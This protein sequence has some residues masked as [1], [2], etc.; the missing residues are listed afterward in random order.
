MFTIW[1]SQHAIGGVLCIV[2]MDVGT[3]HMDEHLIILQS[4]VG[5]WITSFNI[6]MYPVS[7]I[8]FVA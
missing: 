3:Y 7:S 6:L 5:E 2:Y 4:K 8:D 1:S